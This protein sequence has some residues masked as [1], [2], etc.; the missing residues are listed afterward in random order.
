MAKYQPI[1]TDYSL[2][3]RY[4]QRNGEWSDWKEKGKGQFIDIETVQRQIRM[5]ALAYPGREKEV[6]FE[7][8][9][10]LCDMWGNITGN[11]ISLK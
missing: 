4:R 11:V 1:K 9:G 2:E 7:Y 3:I 10:N 6:R 5:I 8:K